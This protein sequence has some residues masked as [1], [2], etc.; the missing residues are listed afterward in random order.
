MSNSLSLH[1]LAGIEARELRSTVEDIYTD[2]Y[3]DAIAS[4]HLFDSVESFMHR[5]DLYVSNPEF[6]MIVACSGK[7]PIGQIWGW[8]L[9]RG[10]R[11]WDDMTP[12][13]D[14]EFSR[15][16]GERTFALSEIMVISEWTGRGVARALHDELLSRRRESRAT[17]FVEPD[18]ER[19][20]RA[21]R[22]WGWFKV[23][24]TRPSWPESPTFDVLI[25][26]LRS[27]RTVEK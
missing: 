13:P 17:L 18:N 24:T 16:D 14:P 1:R 23:G 20:Y 21:Y 9:R 19:A 10:S 3:V 22:S 6:D 25:K 4:G 15:E 8:P 7:R 26:H 5:F 27:D 2:S 11:D 12:V